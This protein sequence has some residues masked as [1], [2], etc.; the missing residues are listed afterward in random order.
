VRGRRRERKL[1][2]TRQ[3]R[4][5]ATRAA[6][7]A[8]AG[9]AI[10]ERGFDGASVELIAKAAGYTKGAFYASFS[11]KE[12]LFL[13]IL[14]ERF[15]AQI[16]RLERALQGAG[17]PATEVRAATEG[18]LEQVSSDP[19]WPRLYQEFATHAARNPAFR[20]EL[21]ARQRRLRGAMAEI[22]ARWSARRGIE[23]PL[24]PAEIAAMSYW[25]A[26][27]FLLQRTL[28]RELEDRLYV[29][30]VETFLAGLMAKVAE[31]DRGERPLAQV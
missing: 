18:F 4:K 19:S 9:E 14:D 16:A 28:D 26:E 10:C 6:L 27:G 11:S 30:L 15:A 13:A 29:E 1:A 31:S 23:P 17:D 21:V 5:A 25:M 24:P 2:P 20:K 7:L 22:F 3:E 12:E 8:A